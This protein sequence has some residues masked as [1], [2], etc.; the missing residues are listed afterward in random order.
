MLCECAWYC[1]PWL[2]DAGRA[3]LHGRSL[4]ASLLPG[5]PVTLAGVTLSGGR[6]PLPSLLWPLC[7]LRVGRSRASQPTLPGVFLPRGTRA[8]GLG[9]LFQR[10]A[11]GPDL[12]LPAEALRVCQTAAD[13]GNQRL[14]GGW[15]AAAPGIPAPGGRSGGDQASAWGGDLQAAR[16]H[17]VTSQRVVPGLQFCPR[18]P[19]VLAGVRG[20][21]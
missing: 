14:G 1:L 10:E 15:G 8:G 13:G 2:L 20:S 12:S 17:Y 9:P 4:P 6:I 7:P 19:Q 5:R 16:G 3:V 11:R 18:Q 21:R